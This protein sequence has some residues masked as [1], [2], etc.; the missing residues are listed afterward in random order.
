MKRILVTLI[1]TIFSF[2]EMMSQVSS[3]SSSS[4]QQNPSGPTQV[5]PGTVGGYKN[6]ITIFQTTPTNTGAKPPKK[7]IPVMT[8]KED[9]TGTRIYRLKNGLTV[10]LSKNPLEPRIQTYIAVRAGSKN[11]PPKTTGLAHYLEHMLFKGTDNIGTT[12]WER[13]R[14]ILESIAQLYEQHRKETNEEKKKELYKEI[15]RLSNEAA[16][17]AIPNEYDKMISSLGAKGT[18]AYTSLEQTVYVNDIPANELERWLIVESE[19]FHRLVLRLF[20]TELE[21]VYEEYNMSQ[22]RDSRKVWKQFMLSMFPS[23]TY[24]TQTTIGEGEHLKNPSLYN[25]MNYFTQYYVPNNMAICMSGDLD[26]DKTIALIDKYFGH[27]ESRPVPDFNVRKEAPIT[28]VKRSDVF[29][30]E[31]ESLMMGF[32]LP[33]ANTKEVKMAKMVAALLSNGQAGLI[34]LNLNQQQK[35]LSANAYVYEL[36]DY[37][38]FIMS[39]SPKEGQTLEE[40]EQLLLAE[41]E[42]VRKGLFEEWLM[43]AVVDDLRLSQTKSYE[44]NSGRASAHVSSFILGKDWKSY[45]E[46]L[47]MMDAFTKNELSSFASASLTNNNY[48]IIYKRKG[49]DNN[50]VKVEKPEITPV[51]ANRDSSSAFLKQWMVLPSSKTQPEFVDYKTAIQETTLNSGVKL[52][53]IPNKIND[54]FELY[55]IFDMGSDHDLELS[56]AINYLPYLGTDKYTAA[57]LQ[58]EFFKYGLSFGVSTSRDRTYVTLSGLEKNIEKGIELFEHILANVK[59]DKEKYAELVNMTLKERSDAKLNKNVILSGAMASY[60]QYGELSPFKNILSEKQLKDIN[61]SELTGKIKDLNAYPH[62]IFYYGSKPQEEVINL[63][64]VYHQLPKKLKT[65]PEAVMFTEQPTEKDR[66]YFVHYD[67][68]Q[69]QIMRISKDENF[70]KELIP[71]AAAF[72]EYFGSGLSSIVFQEIRETKALAYSAYA[73]YTIPAK[74]GDAH[75]VRSYVA[76]QADKMQQAI[77]AMDVIMDEMPKAEAQF[78]QSLEASIKKI[79]SERITRSSIFWN[80]ETASRRGLNYDVRS[81]IYRELQGMSMG[82]LDRF[83]EAHIS[84]R[85]YTYLVIGDRTKLDMDYLKSLGEFRELTLEEVFGY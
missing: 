33:G 10:Y 49:V 84:D 59:S 79:E 13:E 83:F 17:L 15:D 61:P 1:V 38:V 36:K 44:S 73:N 40:C 62:R 77:E 25:I 67:M 47:N 81:D 26:Y 74:M 76:T 28:E 71:A 55:Y 53:Y 2:S 58:E 80:Y 64:D 31:A 37:G 3:S 29:G 35:V 51:E 34:D 65:Y 68:V 85:T 27:Y 50:I 12:N 30:Q 24:G 9:P 82:D 6:P 18:N 4:Q 75:Y 63:L 56:L 42:K 52:S 7:D 70:N 54:L 72:N 57:Q 14:I 19:R 20:H 41:L 46:E 21:A 16:K 66:V 23:S 48:V 60:G 32:R 69:A 78:E 11:D 45:L 39:A 22:D 43:D 8:Y 5:V